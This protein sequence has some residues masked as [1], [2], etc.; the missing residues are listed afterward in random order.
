M[1]II[2]E[3]RGK[4]IS[5][6]I[7]HLNL[8]G[9]KPSI[10]TRIEEHFT[11][12]LRDALRRNMNNLQTQPEIIDCPRCGFNVDK[13]TVECPRCQW[14]F[15]IRFHCYHCMNTQWGFMVRLKDGV[16]VCAFCEEPFKDQDKTQHMKRNLRTPA[17]IITIGFILCLLYIYLVWG[18]I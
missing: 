7:Q 11:K 6:L 10:H 5:V 13:G 4:K 17:I 2:Y 12:R 1:Y 14:R 3:K 16:P 15:N 9:L 8:L 18:Y